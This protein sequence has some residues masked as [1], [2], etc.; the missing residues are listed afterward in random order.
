MTGPF[1]LSGKHILVTGASS[2]IGR[3]CALGAAR[4][5]ARVTL[6][7]RDPA[8]LR[9]TLEAMEGGE[10]HA[11]LPFDLSDPGGIEAFAARV[12]EER[13]P[14]DGLCHCAGA[15]GARPLR[16]SGPAYVE[17][18][19]RINAFAFFQL[20]RSFSLRGRFRDGGSAVVLS[21]VAARRGNRC[22]GAYAASKGAVEAF[23]RP[24]A[25]ELAPRGIRVNAVAC[26]AVD[27]PMSEDYLSAGPPPGQPLGAIPPEAAANAALFLLG[28]ACP[29]ITAAVLPV[30]AGA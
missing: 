4:L 25:L 28:D 15:G 19:F 10:A 3:Q 18:L 30:T 24:A 26:A 22:Q 13:G 16:D 14:L 27:T 2:G 5:G 9:E 17:G 8:R 12:M 6:T 21:S 7:A 29:Y 1:S 23:L 20:V 11:A